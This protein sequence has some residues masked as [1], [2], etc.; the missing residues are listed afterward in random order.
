MGGRSLT[1][2][3]SR[4]LTPPT[5][6]PP[7]SGSPHWGFASTGTR[8]AERFEGGGRRCRPSTNDPV[9]VLRCSSKILTGQRC[10]RPELTAASRWFRSGGGGGVRSDAVTSERS[11]PREAIRLSSPEKAEPIERES[12]SRC[13][14]LWLV[15]KRD[16]T[17][18]CDGPTRNVVGTYAR[19][20]SD[21]SVVDVRGV[22]AARGARR[23][24]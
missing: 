18:R 8:P 10:G 5:D 13:A 12:D 17:T 9:Q 2:R 1:S 11:P 15:R 3:P 21:T 4:F 6:W 14:R 22:P 24:E 23:L 20:V 16:R 19:R 7:P